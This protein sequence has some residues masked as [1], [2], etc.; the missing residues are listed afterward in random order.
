[1][2]KKLFLPVFR[3]IN[4][5]CVSVCSDS[6]E[7]FSNGLS[8]VASFAMRIVYRVANATSKPTA[9]KTGGKTA[10]RVMPV[11]QHALAACSRVATL[12]E[13][14]TLVG[15]RVCRLDTP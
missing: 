10:V 9:A 4:L 15:A 3:R 2:R 7:T 11:M 1:M 14:G 13:Q 5:L 8:G 6:Q 12:R